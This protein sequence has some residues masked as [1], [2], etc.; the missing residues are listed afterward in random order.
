[1]NNTNGV[2]TL[3]IAISDPPTQSEMQ[4]MLAKMNELILALRR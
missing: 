2:A 4:Q 1:L 3:S